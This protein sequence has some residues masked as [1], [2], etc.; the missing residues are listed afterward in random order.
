MITSFYSVF[1]SKLNK[2]KEKLREELKISKHKRNKKFI[3][4][5]IR[6]SRSLK[7]TLEKIGGGKTKICCPKCDHEFIA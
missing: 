1:D 5:L 2:L 3:K 7:Q 6:E 4:D